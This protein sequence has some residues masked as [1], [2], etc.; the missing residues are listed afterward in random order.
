M[1][2]EVAAGCHLFLTRRTPG[3]T[4][5]RSAIFGPIS[6]QVSCRTGYVVIL[7]L[8]HS[9]LNATQ[10]VERGFDDLDDSDWFA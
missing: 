3:D 10:Q 5:R 4:L 2:T 7:F 1:E 6:L 8:Q 9:A